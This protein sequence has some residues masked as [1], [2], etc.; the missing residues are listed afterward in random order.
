MYQCK[1]V[2]FLDPNLP[3]TCENLAAAVAQARPLVLNAV[4][5]VLKLFGEQEYGVKALKSCL[6][7][8]STGSQCP[9]ELGDWLVDQG[10]NLASIFG[11]SVE[12]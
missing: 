1:T 8:I 3:M 10:V 2:Y 11:S 9:D 4:P 6:E 5:Y 7:V 12:C